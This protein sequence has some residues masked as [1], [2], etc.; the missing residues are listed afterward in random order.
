M[1]WNGCGAG[2]VGAWHY[3]IP[4]LGISEGVSYVPL[5]IAGVLIVLFSIEH[6]VALRARRG[7]R[8]RMALTILARHV[9]RAS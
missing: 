9:L 8:A 2:R 1:A 5:V 4:T 6:I 3:K 7:G